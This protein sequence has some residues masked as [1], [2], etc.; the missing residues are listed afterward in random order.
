[1]A[2]NITK[3]DHGAQISCETEMEAQSAKAILLLSGMGPSDIGNPDVKTLTVNKSL[4]E[5]QKK[6]EDADALIVRMNQIVEPLHIKI[7]APVVKVTTAGS[8]AKTLFKIIDTAE[9][10]RQSAELMTAVKGFVDSLKIMGTLEATTEGVFINI[11]HKAL[12]N[13]ITSLNR[14]LDSIALASPPAPVPTPAPAPAPAQPA[15]VPEQ[16]APVPEQSAPVPEQSAPVPE[17]SAPSPAPAPEPVFEVSLPPGVGPKIGKIKVPADQTAMARAFLLL[18]GVA[19]ENISAGKADEDKWM[20]KDN[21]RDTYDTADPI[22]V[23][24]KTDEEVGAII[25]RGVGLYTQLNTAAPN[26]GFTFDAP[27]FR[28]SSNDQYKTSTAPEGA[29]VAYFP[30]TTLSTG[31][32]STLPERMQRFYAAIKGVESMGGPGQRSEGSVID[33]VTRNASDRIK[34]LGDSLTAPAPA[35]PAAVA[36][37]TEKIGNVTIPEAVATQTE[38]APAPIRYSI[39]KTPPKGSHADAVPQ[40]AETKAGEVKPAVAKK[41][42]WK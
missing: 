4:D 6:F 9:P 2:R 16:S 26:Y 7:E 33:F 30:V 5:T 24:G 1:M 39:A 29:F 3:T 13:R 25:N 27:L 28:W 14:A 18:A 38:A 8:P 23:K 32:S 34:E 40:P 37:K 42:W 35:K 31:P 20:S 41:S 21:W 11:Q 19:P 12:F 10:K 15:P 36:P 17:Q 22:R